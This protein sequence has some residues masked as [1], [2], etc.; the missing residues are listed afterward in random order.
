MVW[1]GS[2][3]GSNGPKAFI[4]K[5]EKRRNGYEK[6]F[7]ENH[8][9]APRYTIA[10]TGNVFITEKA[11]AEVS[12]KVV[13]CICSFLFI[14]L[15]TNPASLIEMSFILVLFSKTQTVAG[16]RAMPSIFHNPDWWVLDVMDG[17]GTHLISKEAKTICLKN[18]ILRLKEEGDSSSI[19]QAYDKYASKEK[20][21]IQHN[22]LTILR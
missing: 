17:F 2:S 3:F 14:F 11:W 19:N 21:C 18:K 9:L 15:W 7:L 4:I 8:G 1:S 6:M 10:M 16:Y 20:N 5:D 13:M 12:V 22:N